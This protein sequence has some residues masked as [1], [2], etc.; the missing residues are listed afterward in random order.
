MRR[1]AVRVTLTLL[2]VGA[3]GAAAYLCWTIQTRLDAGAQTAAAFDQTRVAALR[4]AYELRWAQQ[5][6]VAAGQ[7]ETFWFGKVTDASESLEAGL[8]TLKSSTTSEP[9]LASLDEA[10]SALEDF[11]QIDRRA[12]TYAST[13]QKLLASDV[14]FSDGLEAAG[15]IIAALEQSG[16]AVAESLDIAAAD[17]TR[18]QAMVAGGA[19]AAAMLVLL[20]LMPVVA[21]PAAA[22]PVP[23]VEPARGLETDDDLD[24]T[25]LLDGD[26][27]EATPANVSPVE[28]PLT[29]APEVALEIQGLANVCSDLARL[30]DTSLLPGILERTAAALDASG[31]VLWIADPD[32]KELLPVAAHGYPA[33]VL[34]RMGSLRADD[35]NATAAA[36]RTGLLQTVSAGAMSNGAIAVP[37]V[38]PAGCR[39]VMSAEVRPGA[40]KQ[41][42]RLAAA[43]IIAAQLATLVGPPAAR[44]QD[45]NTASL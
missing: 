26:I 37:L 10:D 8:A 35:E 14:I 15:R 1:R 2:A 33:N 17:A 6:Y 39:G 40:E 19:A 3:I 22:A 43:A 20:L 23:T 28:A 5:A 41:P 9:A 16:A 7:N 24:F 29:A 34:N 4:D 45:R 38:T 36:F 18:E 42:A 27:R 31:L 11:G 12:R 44:A 13:G 30:S 25:S 21:A 32:G